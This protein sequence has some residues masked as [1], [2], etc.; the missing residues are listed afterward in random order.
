MPTMETKRT[1]EAPSATFAFLIVTLYHYLY[2]NA[3]VFPLNRF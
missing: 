3:V 2:H 1:L